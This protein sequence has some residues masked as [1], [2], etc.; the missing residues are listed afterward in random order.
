MGST[1]G[2]RREGPP[3]SPPASAPAGLPDH[4]LHCGSQWLWSSAPA[5]SQAVK[6]HTLFISKNKFA[7]KP[8]VWQNPW[9]RDLYQLMDQMGKA[10]ELHIL[11]FKNSVVIKPA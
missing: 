4:P 2:Q 9:K 8:L 11:L 6:P 3:A 1:K 5:P 7:S 10:K